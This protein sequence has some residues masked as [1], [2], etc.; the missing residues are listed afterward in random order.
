VTAVKFIFYANHSGST[1]KKL[2]AGI[3]RA[4]IQG[5]AD[6]QTLMHVVTAVEEAYTNISRHAYKNKPGKIETG[7]RATK[8]QIVVSLKDWGEPFEPCRVRK[9]TPDELIEKKIEGGLGMMMM[10]RLVDK[11]R[12]R[13]A[14]GHNEIILVKNQVKKSKGGKGGRA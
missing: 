8:K 11:V 14:D 6:R 3:A 12:F 4:C 13:R 9:R 5:G 1:I 10:E 2:R 7:V